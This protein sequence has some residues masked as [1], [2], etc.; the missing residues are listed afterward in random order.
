[1][2][3]PLQCGRLWIKVCG[4]TSVENAAAVANCGVD[5]LG[6]NFYTRSK[7][8]I[9]AATAAAIVKVTADHTR[10]VGLFVNTEA[11]EI[12]R[13]CDA[14][15]IETVQ[16]HG[17]E[18]TSLIDE[19]QGSDRPLTV[20]RAVRL[21]SIATDLAWDDSAPRPAALLLDAASDAGFGGTGQT[22]D[23]KALPSA[24]F[25]TPNSV[26]L[27]LAGGL[28]AE[29]VAE[30]V[31]ASQADGVDVASGVESEPGIKDIAMVR[32]FVD[33]ARSAAT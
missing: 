31:A 1:M 20:I 29:N 6:L 24:R 2:P 15:G 4:L 8:V 26:P 17:D 19:L 23:W 7:R 18:P 13:V 14:T 22:L 33:E 25:R 9:D 21:R 12:R 30:A 3:T 32:R 27:V 5:A 16:L 11:A 28:T 10:P